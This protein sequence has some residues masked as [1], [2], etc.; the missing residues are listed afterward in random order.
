MILDNAAI[1]RLAAYAK[2]IGAEGSA[3]GIKSTV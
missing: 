1:D 3:L 2:S